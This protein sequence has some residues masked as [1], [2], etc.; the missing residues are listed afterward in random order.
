MN[1]KKLFI[2]CILSLF[3]VMSYAAADVNI[4]LGGYSYNGPEQT[5]EASNI[6]F[7]MLLGRGDGTYTGVSGRRDSQYQF[8]AVSGVYFKLAGVSI[9]SNITIVHR[10][11]WI[12]VANNLCANNVA[13]CTYVSTW[14]RTNKTL[15]IVSPNAPRYQSTAAVYS[16]LGGAVTGGWAF[17]GPEQVY[18]ANGVANAMAI[19]GG[20]GS[21]SGSSGGR[22]SNY[23]F[24]ATN[25]VYFTLNGAKIGSS[26]RIIHG[27]DI[28]YIYDPTQRITSCFTIFLSMFSFSGPTTVCTTIEKLIAS[29]GRYTQ[30]IGVHIRD[31]PAVT[32]EPASSCANGAINPPTCTCQPGEIMVAGRCTYTPIQD[33]VCGS[34]HA[35]SRP[36]TPAT[37]LCSVGTSTAVQQNVFG[38]TWTWSCP[39]PTVGI[40]ARCW[41]DIDHCDN[42]AT[43]PP[44]C[45]GCGFGEILRTK[46]LNLGKC[47]IPSASLFFQ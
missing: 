30:T 33:G 21:Y 9:G 28:V 31:I 18:E 11:D 35:T 24:T 46:G 4:T 7:A 43:N 22:D 40:T 19:A 37:N 47:V 2:A 3:P 12:G 27:Q 8:Q 45:N 41:S 17:N 34:A 10:Q 23:I 25:G 44:Q 15:T 42:G 1:Y 16:T 32:I 13:A 6:F 39:S 20:L 38:H 29:W 14:G 5:S 36:T 26:M